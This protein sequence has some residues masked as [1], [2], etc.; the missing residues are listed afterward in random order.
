MGKSK[1]TASNV[2][3]N[4]PRSRLGP[5][6]PLLGDSITLPY[7]KPISTSRRLPTSPTFCSPTPSLNKHHLRRLSS[8][9]SATILHTFSHLTVFPLPPSLFHP[10]AAREFQ[11]LHA[12]CAFL[13]A[14]RP[15]PPNISSF[16]VRP[17]STSLQWAGAP[18]AKPTH[19]P[20]PGRQDRRDRRGSTRRSRKKEATFFSTEPSR[21]RGLPRLPNPIRIAVPSVAHRSPACQFCRATRNSILVL[22]RRAPGERERE[23]AERN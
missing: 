7:N 19:T 8:P 16:P 21:R 6:I 18:E 9:K 1:S 12:R 13:F 15:I 4:F 11:V 2:L 20:S 10:P 5:A 3:V 23:K 17:R 22:V 14:Q